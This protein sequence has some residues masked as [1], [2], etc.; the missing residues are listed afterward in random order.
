MNSLQSMWLSQC[1]VLKYLDIGAYTLEYINQS[2]VY[3]NSNIGKYIDSFF[4][5]TLP[6][7][8]MDQVKVGECTRKIKIYTQSGNLNSVCVMFEN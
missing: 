8:Y 1:S 7:I 6:I 5:H 3:I 4:L 2:H